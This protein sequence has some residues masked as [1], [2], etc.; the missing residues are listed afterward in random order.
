MH[1][2]TSANPLTLVERS[3]SIRRLVAGLAAVVVSV[4]VGGSAIAAASGPLG[5]A[6]SAGAEKV[7]V[8]TINE[9]LAASSSQT[10]VLGVSI[11]T[12]AFGVAQ[13]T[14]LEDG[15]KVQ[16]LE[17]ERQGVASIALAVDGDIVARANEVRDEEFHLDVAEPGTYDVLAIS[18]G[19]AVT[20]GDV[21]LAPSQQIDRLGRV[22]LD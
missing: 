22:T 6:N 3:A 12:N 9:D 15:V 10:E 19:E 2:T 5:A 17:S 13:I 1:T 21:R 14:N 18:T 16:V 7:S 11:V 20:D 4:M 8:E